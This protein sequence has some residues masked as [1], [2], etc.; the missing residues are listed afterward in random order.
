MLIDAG[1]ATLKPKK[2]KVCGVLVYALM[3]Y[4]CVGAWVCGR[5]GAWVYG[6]MGVR[7]CGC[8]VVNNDVWVVDNELWFDGP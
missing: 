3:L 2:R 1:A 6:C 8:M 4:W 7:V 5:D